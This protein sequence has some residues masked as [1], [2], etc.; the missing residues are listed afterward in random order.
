MSASLLQPTLRE[1]LADAGSLAVELRPA[2][3]L[4]HEAPGALRAFRAICNLRNLAAVFYFCLLVAVARFLQS[5]AVVGVEE[6][7]F[8]TVRFVRQC[9]I[10]GT[11]IM[12]ALALADA[13]AVGRTWS[14]RQVFITAFAA[15]AVAAASARASATMMMVP[16]IRHWRTK[17][18][19]ENAHSS[20][21]TTARLWRKRA[22]A[23]SRHK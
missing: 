3:A 11:I 19:V 4:A 13:A 23:T 15:A 1:S 17:R 14:R 21:P 8:S 6:W 20:R 12:V 2:P 16:L 9:L 22:T 5:L 10:S 18:T 7:A